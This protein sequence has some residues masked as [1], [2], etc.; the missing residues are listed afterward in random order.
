[1][2]L[3]DRY[4]VLLYKNAPSGRWKIPEWNALLD[5]IEFQDT[6]WDE[7]R[8]AME[9]IRAELEANYWFMS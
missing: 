3:V 9:G 6:N 5:H 8:A 1:M 2:K 4:G 7:L